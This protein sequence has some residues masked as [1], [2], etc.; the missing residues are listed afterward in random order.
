VAVLVGRWLVAF[1]AY[2]WNP[3]ASTSALFSIVMFYAQTLSLLADTGT[4]ST[5]S[6][7]SVADDSQASLQ[8]M[9]SI[10]EFFRW[11]ML[12]LPR[13]GCLLPRFGHL[14]GQMWVACLTGPAL[15]LLCVPTLLLAQ[16]QQNQTQAKR[17]PSLA[18]NLDDDTAAIA[19]EGNT[20]T[21]PCCF[22]TTPVKSIRMFL[23]LMNIAF[24][25]IVST[26]VL[27]MNCT[28]LPAGPA[29]STNDV[30]YHTLRP[31]SRCHPATRWGLGIPM[32][33]LY[34]FAF[35]LFIVIH[36]MRRDNLDESHTLDVRFLYGMYKEEHRWW[37]A[38][39][40]LRRFLMP[41]FVQAFGYRSPSSTFCLFA[42]LALSAVSVAYVRPHNRVRDNML[43]TLSLVALIVTYFFAALRQTNNDYI[44]TSG[45]KVITGVVLALNVLT[46]AVLVWCLA[47]D[48]K[49]AFAFVHR[50]CCGRRPTM[51]WQ[52]ISLPPAFTTHCWRIMKTQ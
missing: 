14:K 36:I 44:T 31:Y 24:V 52:S 48:F 26:L 19:D 30:Y 34:G 20:H 35:P 4:F 11:A 15:A 32:L 2:N 25:Q 9:S 28:A 37:V 13:S 27:W 21:R 5:S 42:V 6:D 50:E 51:M 29:G 47:V 10:T 39:V 22:K 38:V 23:F 17:W 3:Q 12:A 46:M 8:T 45:G 41:V 18:R 40:F 16:R 1:V 33:L 43:D 7:S 49:W